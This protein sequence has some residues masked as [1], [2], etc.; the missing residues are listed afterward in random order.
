MIK[1]LFLRRSAFLLIGSVLLVLVFCVV[2]SVELSNNH[3]KEAALRDLELQIEE[4][5][6]KN[7][8]VRYLINDEDPIVLYEQFA[9]EQGYVYPDEKVYYDVTPGN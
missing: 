1:K 3:K 4:V 9:R 6:E 5:V 2:L 8:G 7:N